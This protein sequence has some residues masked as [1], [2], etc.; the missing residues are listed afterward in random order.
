MLVF[1]DDA[2]L[3]SDSFNN[4]FPEYFSNELSSIS[5]PSLGPVHDP[6]SPSSPIPLSP[7]FLPTF[8]NLALDS[9]FLLS[10]P[11]HDTTTLR[12]RSTSNA[13]DRDA[14]S[15]YDSGTI[16]TLSFSQSVPASR[17]VSPYLWSTGDESSTLFQTGFK[18][19]PFDYSPASAYHQPSSFRDQ[20]TDGLLS[21]Q[22]YG[23]VS[24]RSGQLPSN[25]TGNSH[26]TQP[27]LIHATQ[28]QSQP[29]IPIRYADSVRITGYAPSSSSSSSLSPSPSISPSQSPLSLS[30]SHPMPFN[31][32]DIINQFPTSLAVPNCS[33]VSLAVPNTGLHQRRHSYTAGSRTYLSPDAALG[34]RGRG[35]SRVNTAP[36]SRL[37]SHSPYA[38]ARDLSS[39]STQNAG[40]FSYAPVP[41]VQAPSSP[42]KLK[43]TSE[44]TAIASRSRRKEPDAP[45]KHAC[46]V[47]GCDATFTAKHNLTRT[48]YLVSLPWSYGILLLSRY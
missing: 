37:H 16:D 23:P 7:S 42:V 40:E 33:S 44:R 5:S 43:V 31:E 36:A 28:T 8:G 35:L 2:S 10:S 29:E 21:E 48:F 39:G 19:S 38:R 22:E 46:T 26:M 27:T 11:A 25:Q 20:N 32:Q 30:P 1:S 9:D 13:G 15:Q 17:S 14:Y 41:T 4:E 6:Q 12:P 24:F 3:N 18:S 47:P 45:A 34:D